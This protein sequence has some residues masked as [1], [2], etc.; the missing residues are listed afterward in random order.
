MESFAEVRDLCWAAADVSV[1]LVIWACS[2]TKPSNV[3][4]GLCRLMSF[5]NLEQDRSSPSALFNGSLDIILY[6]FLRVSMVFTPFYGFIVNCNPTTMFQ[7]RHIFD[8]SQLQMALS[9][10][11]SLGTDKVSTDISH[12]IQDPSSIG[13]RW[14]PTFCF[15][16]M[17]KTLSSRSCV[18]LWHVVSQHLAPLSFFSSV[19]ILSFLHIF[20]F[21]FIFILFSSLFSFFFLTLGN[22]RCCCRGQ[23]SSAQQ[24]RLTSRVMCCRW[25]RCCDV[26]SMLFCGA[27]S[28]TNHRTRCLS[29]AEPSK[30]S[31][32]WCHTG[33]LCLNGLHRLWNQSDYGDLWRRP[34]RVKGCQKAFTLAWMRCCSKL[35]CGR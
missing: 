2:F 1:H 16:W 19:F 33:S 22:P 12:H 29:H 18:C 24:S 20:S 7:L 26:D 32:L 5:V 17:P 9:A 34:W 4:W 10:V 15:T 3:E 13:K 25:H 27:A 23:S 35:G 30:S 14:S 28:R 8:H 6:S 11:G 21:S 31:E